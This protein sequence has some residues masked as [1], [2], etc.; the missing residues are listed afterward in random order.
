M[1]ISYFLCLR[2]LGL[3]DFVD[4]WKT[5]LPLFLKL[6]WLTF[7]SRTAVLETLSIFCCPASLLFIPTFAFS[8]FI[9]NLLQFTKSPFSH[10]QSA[11]KL[12]HRVISVIAFF[13]LGFPFFSQSA[14]S[15]FR[16][17][18]YFCKVFNN[19][20]VVFKHQRHMYFKVYI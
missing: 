7:P 6:L 9:P 15:L 11:V 20:F 10:V 1:W 17:L 18:S 13:F 12:I 14:L 3:H 16:M 4:S 5:P 8:Y 2:F 19:I